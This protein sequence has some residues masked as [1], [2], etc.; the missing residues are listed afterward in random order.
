[1]S[2]AISIDTREFKKAIQFVRENTKKDMAEILNQ[3]AF[4]IA[5]RT[6]D[7]MLPKPG[8]EAGTRGKIKQYM[9]TPKS[10]PKLR[11]V[12]SGP[13]R[14]QLTRVGRLKNRLTLKNLIIQKR[15]SKQGLKGLYGAEMR[16]L[17]GDL[18]RRAQVGVGFLKTPFLPIIK[19]LVALVK[20][21]KVA[22]RWGRIS[23]WPGSRGFGK[24]KPAKAGEKPFV[25]MKLAW[26]VPGRPGKV[27]RM[28]VPKLQ[29]A[30]NAEAKE[31]VRHT[32][33]QLQK[34]AGKVNA[35]WRKSTFQK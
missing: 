34:T 7:S 18:S 10:E 31:M 5:A 11:V 19:G 23:V 9:D 35:K 30:F 8:A 17:S 21:K 33:A 13:K 28:I 4:N 14:G 12:Q 24:V 3:R 25:E 15:R 29:A 32:T 20:F 1:M 6:V 27:E 2:G 26:N 16:E 22:T